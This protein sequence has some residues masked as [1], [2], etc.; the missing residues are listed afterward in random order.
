MC[1]TILLLLE[2]AD[3]R[4]KANCTFSTESDN[5][6]ANQ[7]KPYCGP[8]LGQCSVIFIIKTSI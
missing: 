5:L 4:D 1:G 8:K 7:W 3:G 6:T 2:S